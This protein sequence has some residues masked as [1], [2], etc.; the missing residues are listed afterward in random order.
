[1]KTLLFPKVL[2][3]SLFIALA[4]SF[5]SCTENLTSNSLVKQSSSGICHDNSSGAFNR[6]KNYIPFDTIAACI[7]AGGRLPKGK[8][9]QIDDATNDAI[10]EG[11]AFV[12][13]YDRSDW[14]HW[15]DNDKDCQNTRHEIL[16]QT[17]TKSVEFKT[18]KECNVLSGEWYDPYSGDTFTIS[19]DLD[20]DHIVPLKFA[21]GHGAD[22]W[23]RERKAMLANDLDNLI[24]A[25]ASLNRQKG[26]KGLTEWLPPNFSYRCEY[27]AR[28][29]AVMAKYELS[30]IQSEQRIVNR[31]VKACI[32]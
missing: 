6:T 17:S 27:I 8:T 18:E 16:I 19:K 15:L 25:K 5:G 21:H 1:M 29:N 24:L 26:A 9:N 4:I 31:M 30:Y 20:L 11:R 3:L 23:S 14:P 32:K 28:F 7:E 12:T 10:H 13:L 22:K 2:S